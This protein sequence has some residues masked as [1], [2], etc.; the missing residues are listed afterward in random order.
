MTWTPNY[1][2]T[3]YEFDCDTYD[4]N[5]AYNPAFTRCRRA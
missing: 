4:P 5:V 1:W 3:G 2:T